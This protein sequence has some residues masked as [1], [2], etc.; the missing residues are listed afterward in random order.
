MFL[1]NRTVAIVNLKQ[2]FADWLNSLSQKPDVELREDSLDRAHVFLLP[3]ETLDDEEVTGEVLEHYWK[4]MALDIF[5]AWVPDS[6]LWP[7]DFSMDDFDEWFDL[8]I[9]DGEVADLVEEPLERDE[10]ELL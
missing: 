2:P 6:K 1:V 10:F 4:K 7:K 3:E 5:A 9:I 8:A